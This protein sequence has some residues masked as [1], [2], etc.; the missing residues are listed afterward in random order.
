MKKKK[1]YT[2]DQNTSKYILQEIGK[3]RNP[4]IALE[5]KVVKNGGIYMRKL[6]RNKKAMI[7]SDLW[8][9]WV[10]DNLRGRLEK[11]NQ[12]KRKG[13]GGLWLTKIMG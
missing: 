6:P 5:S 4:E 13:V 8:L 10:K 11:V 12:M 3:G 7:F 9:G 1:D 2:I